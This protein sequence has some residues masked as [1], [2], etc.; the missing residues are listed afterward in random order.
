MA[1]TLTELAAEIAVAQA[2]HSTMSPEETSELLKKTFSCLQE[3]KSV[4]DGTVE[5]EEAQEAMDPKKSIQRNKVICLECGKEFRQLTNRHLK[6]HDIT[7]KEYRKKYGFGARQPLSA[8]TLTAARRKSAKERDL[9][10]L[11]KKAR[12]QKGKK[13]GKA[14]K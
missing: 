14:K 1:K 13:K 10:E 7:T 3:I 9:G 2:S 4:E 5:A 8:K 12:A 6:E 11:L